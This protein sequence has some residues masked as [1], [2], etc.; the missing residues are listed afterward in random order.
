MLAYFLSDGRLR[1]LLDDP[2][3]GIIKDKRQSINSK[4]EFPMRQWV[5]V[6]VVQADST[7]RLFIDGVLDAAENDCV[8]PV[9]KSRQ[10]HFIGIS[11][12]YTRSY[13][14]RDTF[15]HGTWWCATAY[16]V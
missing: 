4:F 12:E 16:P 3:N 6:A 11:P 15:F 8:V 13:S 14:A 5:H 7:I 1:Y 10:Y 9:R 2:S